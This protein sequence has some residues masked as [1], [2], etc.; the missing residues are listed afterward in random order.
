MKTFQNADQ[1]FIETY[2]LN[3]DK[4]LAL[5]NRHSYARASAE[6]MRKAGVKNATPVHFSRRYE[7]E[8]IRRIQEQFK[9]ALE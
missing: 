8:E 4:E 3:E 2:Y 7:E 1:V 5:Q 6:V 9:A